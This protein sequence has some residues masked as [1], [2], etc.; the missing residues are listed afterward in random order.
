MLIVQIRYLTPENYSD[1]TL[2]RGLE[3]RCGYPVCANTIEKKV[4]AR[5]VWHRM[6]HV[7]LFHSLGSPQQREATTRFVIS[8]KDKQVY[9]LHDRA[10]F[11]SDKCAIASQRHKA[12][13]V[14]EAVHL[15]QHVMYVDLHCCFPITRHSLAA[16]NLKRRV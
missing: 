3:G 15:R 1:V 14:D 6:E 13:L 7:K 5:W 10:Y 12:Q 11:C 4:R 2:E 16:F 8:P 9:E